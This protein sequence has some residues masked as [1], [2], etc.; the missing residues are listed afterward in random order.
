MGFEP[1]SARVLTTTPAERPEIKHQDDALGCIF[2]SRFLVP[3]ITLLS[4]IVNTAETIRGNTIFMCLN[5]TTIQ[6]DRRGPTGGHYLVN[7]K[8]QIDIWNLTSHD[9]HGHVMAMCEI[10]AYVRWSMFCKN[11]GL[12][13]YCDRENGPVNDWVHPVRQPTALHSRR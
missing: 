8:L 9:L 4:C 2:L 6:V 13:K 12:A 5:L 1:G 7:C 11:I 3:A 10:Q